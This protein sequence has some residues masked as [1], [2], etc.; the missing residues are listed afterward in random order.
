MARKPIDI[1]TIGNDGTGDSIRDAFRKVNDNFRELYSSLGLGERLTFLGLDDTPDVYEDQENALVTVN[2][3]TNG[4]SFRKLENG[5]G[6]RIDYEENRIVLNNLFADISGDPSPNLGGPFNAQFGSTRSPLGNLIDISNSDELNSAR[7]AMQTV[8]GILAANTDRL[9]SNKGYTDTKISIAGVDAIDPASGSVDTSFGEMTGPLVLSRDPIAE[10][11]DIWDGRVAATKRY[12]DNSGFGSSV[13]LYVATSG[14]DD[15]PSLNKNLQGRALS[16]AYRTIEATLKRAEEIILEAPIE[17]G[18]YKKILTYNNGQN[19]CSLEDIGEV[20]NAGS[21]FSG[22]LYMSVESIDIDFGGELYLTGDIISVLGGTF[23]QAASVEVLSVNV[24]PGTG[25]RGSVKNIRIITAGVYTA[26]PGNTGIATTSNSAFGKNLTVNLTYNVNNIEVLDQGSGY[27]LVSVRIQGG[28]GRGAFG[29]ADVVNGQISG[30]TVTNKGSGFTSLPNVIVNLPRFFIKTEGFRT[31]FTGNIL[32]ST[33]LA[34]RTRDIREGLLLQGETSGAIAQILSHRGDLSSESNTLGCEIFDVDLLSGEFEIGEVISY[35]DV[36]KRVQITVFVETGTYEENYPLRIPQNVAIVGDEFRRTIIKPKKSVQGAPMSGMSSS[37]WASLLFRRDTTVDGLVTAEENFGYHYLSDPTQ[38]VYNIVNNR[39]DRRAA[40]SLLEINREFIKTQVIGWINNQIINETNGFT[41]DFEYDQVLWRRDLGLVIDAIVFD[42]KYGGYTR[43]VSAALKYFTRLDSFAVITDN[44]SETEASLLRINA[45]AQEIIS[46]TQ[47]DLVY[48]LNGTAFSL[49]DVS[50]TLKL[51]E[52]QIIDRAY[53]SETG[54]GTVVSELI[55][56]VIDIISNSGAANYPKDNDQLDVFL[57]NDAN[58]VRAV[59]CQGHGGFMMVLDP[60]GQILTK[61]PYCQES[62]SFSRSTGKKTFAGGLFVDGFTGNQQF[63]ITAA[64]ETS[65]GLSNILE[66]DG[67]L[68]VPNTP[69]SFIV[70]DT[71]YRINYIRNYNYAVDYPTTESDGTSQWYSAAQL[72]LD[73][74]TPWPFGVF[75]YNQDICRRDV[76][77]IVDGLGYDL[78]FQ[79]NYHQRRAGL[80]YRQANAQVVVAGQLDITTRAITYAHQQVAEIIPG[81]TAEVENSATVI[82]LIIENGTATAPT[83]NLPSPPGLSTNK[84]NAKTLLLANIEYIKEQT[85]L[86]MAAQVSGSIAP[87]SPSFVFDSVSYSRDFGYLVE[88]VVYDLIYGGNSQTRDVALR[89]YDGVGDAIVL[90]LEVGQEDETGAAI[91]HLNTVCKAVIQNTNPVPS[92]SGT[93]SRVSGTPATITEATIIDTLLDGVSATVVGGVGSAPALVAVNLSSYSYDSNRLS[94][95][96]EILAG[97]ETV[98]DDT[99]FWINLNANQYEI[100]MPGNRSMLSNDYTQV[101][102]LGYGLIVANGGLTEA[103]SMFTYYCHISYYA[104]TGGQI[105]SIGG[106]SSHGNYGLVAEGSDP[107][108]VPTPAGLYHQLAQGAT[109]FAATV[110]TQNAKGSVTLFVNYDEYLPLNGSELEVNHNNLFTRYVVSSATSIDSATN[111]AR[112]NISSA[113]GLEASI[114]NGTRVVIRQNSFVTLTGDVVNVATRPSTAFVF[115]EDNYVYRVLEFND[116]DSTYDKDVFTITNID[117]VTGIITTDVPHRQRTG[118]QIKI[119]KEVGDILPAVISANFEGPPIVSGEIYYIESVPTPTSFTI[120]T[121]KTGA[122]IDL[123]AGPAYSGTQTATVVPFGL[124]LTQ[125]REN[126]SYIVYDLYEVQPFQTPGSLTSCTFSAA[127]PT[128]VSA[129]SHGL[130]IGSQIRFDATGGSIPSGIFAG[131]YYW[132]VSKDYGANSFKITDSPPISST[133]VGINGALTGLTI[134]GLSNTDRLAPGMRLVSKPSISI[135]GISGNGTTATITFTK[136]RRVP[137]LNGQ[138]ISISGVTNVGFNNATASVISC[139]TTSVTYLNSTSGTSSGGTVS[140]VRTGNLGTNPVIASITNPTTIVITNG[141]G[142]TDGSVVFDVEGDEI[143]VT[144]TGSLVKFGKLLGDQGQTTIAVTDLPGYLEDRVLNT[145]LYYEGTEYKVVGYIPNPGGA[146]YSVITLDNPLEVSAISYSSPISLRSAIDATTNGAKGTLTIRI[147][148]VRVTSHDFLEIGTGGYADTNYPNDIFGPAVNDF[149]G[150][151]LYATDFDAAGATVTR[152]QVQERDVGRSFFVTTDQYGNF[153]VGPFFKV[154]Q[155]TGTVTFSASIALSQLDGLGF[156]RGATVSEFSVDDSMS[157]GA[158]DTVPTEAA[159]RGYIDRR[160]GLSHTGTVVLSNNLIPLGDAG[161]F[162]ALSGQLS[163]KGDMDL[164][165][166]KIRNLSSPVLETDAARLADINITNL[167]DSD[168]TDLFTF[169][170]IQA[171]QLLALTGDRNTVGNFTAA[172]DVLFDI[173]T[174]DSTTNTIRTSIASGVIV[175]DDINSSAA[176]SQS[177]LNMNAA[178]TRVDAVGI[179]QAQRGLTS[180]DDA[181]FTVTSG[182][183]TIKDTGISLS[184]IAQIGTKRVL[185]NP[186]ATTSASPS[187][188]TYTDVVSDG[189]AIKKSQFSSGVGY[190]KRVN[191]TTGAFT[192]DGHYSIINDDSN[193]TANTLVRRDANK[194]FAGRQ[195]TVDEL[196]L[197]T[198]STGTYTAIRSNEVTTVNGFTE[199]FGYGGGGG[200]GFVGVGIGAGSTAANNKTN[201]NNTTHEFRS[202]N[203]ATTFATLDNSGL[204]LGSRTV[205]AGT[206]TGVTTI[207]TGAVGTAGTITGLWTLTAGSRMQATYAADLAEFYEGD[208]EYEVGTVLVFGGDKEVTISDKFED[209]RVAG[210]VSDNAAYSMNGGCPGL[211]NQIALQGRVPCKIVGKVSKGDILITSSIPGVAIA[212]GE[213]IKVGTMIGKALEEHNSDEIG[214]IEVSVGRT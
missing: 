198:T 152:A 138:S 155:G 7:V 101:N 209:R 206:L 190:I 126:Y 153:A 64:P 51:T 30:I 62:A 150:V 11:D 213:D 141:G 67:L 45:I 56:A 83:L 25:G 10:D 9:A 154:D 157:D 57:C 24:V 47:I 188:V 16:F 37:P 203:G 177:K 173:Q 111:L 112:L 48:T 168:G 72:I 147:A 73:E 103:V 26:L 41:S 204:N 76:G 13:N 98:Q 193:S 189:G 38:P 96:T 77:L 146:I 4:L 172:G 27:G 89:Y 88:A 164:N 113:A 136:Q 131:E 82:N 169:T 122:R 105:R 109:V 115:N 140:P 39:G 171:G 107:L 181:Q 185:G 69:C 97:K 17:V 71:I 22:Q 191:A 176:I 100:L 12:V 93:Y 66:I 34:I 23:V 61:S 142:N 32:S 95:R 158:N 211:K 14:Q 180:F 106:S 212:A 151:P 199:L 159:V 127:D 182:W 148:L 40:S 124:A 99:V 81:Y 119:K 43:T 63:R 192:D 94:A 163:M 68:R 6:I 183:A 196:K 205:T 87:F 49:S 130:A 144:T 50:N 85:L 58:I 210:I 117:I 197:T 18:P 8:H 202:Q 31:D 194:D 52:S 174:G 1:G 80:L 125:F 207:S 160:L 78:V 149:N 170:E 120:S 55:T 3:T 102:D 208:A 166:F 108:E 20:E 28:G 178:T 186:S 44:L 65:P 143:G 33:P 86:W 59:T 162:M 91:D 214:V 175:N 184:K 134:S 21:G 179:V 128:V 187:A 46:N 114:P 2:S 54:S 200:S 19:Q 121:T 139:T 123:S 79:S 156:K 60:E 75:E 70:D 110:S 135:T 53:V 201:Y 161:G 35:G 15:R 74:T 116:Y 145:I 42:L 195:V 129:V 118:L 132:V 29:R 137:F 36:T 84:S 133:H 165:N 90:Q 167:K 5:T 92:Y 104:L